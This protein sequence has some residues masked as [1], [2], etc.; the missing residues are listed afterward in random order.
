[1]EKELILIGLQCFAEEDEPNEDPVGIDDLDE[2]EDD[3]GIEEPEDS[4]EEGPEAT[5]KSQAEVDQAIKNRLARE[6]KKLA[7]MFGVDKLDDIGPYLQAGM[8]VSQSAGVSPGEVVNRLSGQQQS[9]QQQPNYRGYSP[10]YSQPQQDNV[11]S[12]QLKQIQGMLESE[13]EEKVRSQQETLAKK[14][15]GKLYDENY[16]DILDKAEETGL[17]LVDAATIVLR[18]KL[19]E[20][21]ANQQAQKKRVKG[22]RK[23]ESSSESPSGGDGD[24]S[25]KLSDR[26]KRV[27]QKMNM[28]YKD[29]YSQL[30]ALGRTENK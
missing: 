30:K 22:Q 19:R 3:Y 15:F 21:L 1:M 17:S 18:P 10:G 14:E 2:P 11:T 26:E 27:A 12:Q 29:Y 7:K 25:S 5:Y 28:S 4:D 20:H 6:R 13:R 16:E 9:Q 24:F 8:A 23:V